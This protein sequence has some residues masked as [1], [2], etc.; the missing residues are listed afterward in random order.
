MF[1]MVSSA[2]IGFFAK[3]SCDMVPK[4]SWR[5]NSFKLSFCISSYKPASLDNGPGQRPFVTVIVGDK[6]KKTELG[7]W[8]QQHGEWQFRETITL[9]VAP[10][11]E[12][13]I[14]VS[15]SQQ[16]DFG[17]A[18]VELASSLLGEVCFPVSSVLPKLRAEE[19]DID[20]VVHTTQVIGFDIL[21]AG[22]RTGRIFT[23]METRHPP[24]SQKS[25]SGVLSIADT[26][27]NAKAIGDKDGGQG[28]SSREHMYSERAASDR[29]HQSHRN[30]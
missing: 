29:Y 5:S 30:Y 19:R 24:S 16:Y 23:A 11:D 7:T 8:S 3:A 26:C 22:A 28:P 25:S 1:G 15:C 27:I 10:E 14:Q 2:A 17:L 13:A 20:G 4:V 21:N 12:V 6:K 9:E 18:A